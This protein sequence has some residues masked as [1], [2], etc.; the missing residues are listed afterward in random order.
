MNCDC[1][2]ET[3]RLGVIYSVLT[4]E[5][6]P[7]H[8]AVDRLIEALQA[9]AFGAKYISLRGKRGDLDK[10]EAAE[11]RAK[12]LLDELEQAQGTQIPETT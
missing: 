6:C 12:A 5:H 11:E 9:L 4:I 7:K 10:F 3:D 8:A 1:K 2:V